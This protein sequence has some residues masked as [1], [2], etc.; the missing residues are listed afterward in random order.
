MP[1]TPDMSIPERITA[2]EDALAQV[3]NRGPQ[4]SVEPCEPP[5]DRAVYVIDQP[6]DQSRTKFSLYQM[7]RE[8]E[9]LL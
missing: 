6:Y 3:L 4:M 1:L 7:A 5:G 9:V 2:I 8:L